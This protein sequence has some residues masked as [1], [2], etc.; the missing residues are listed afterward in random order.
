M[1]TTVAS[2]EWQFVGQSIYR[3]AHYWVNRY[4]T[5]AGCQV[6]SDWAA[7]A[8]ASA[9]GRYVGWRDSNNPDDVRK[10]V[11]SFVR[12]G[13]RAAVNGAARSAERKPA[14]T[15]RGRELWGVAVPVDQTDDIGRLLRV[16]AGLPEHLARTAW[17]IAQHDGVPTGRELAGE[18][19]CCLWTAQDR[20][21]KLRREPA[22]WS[23][24]LAHIAEVAAA[25]I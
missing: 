25:G 8:V 11:H 3:L 19:G 24:L 13:A 23:L 12:S 16:I 18:L 15:N 10:T 14:E 1:T 21:R 5:A 22:L 7:D 17:V 4:A 6:D 20:L 2:A 9:Y